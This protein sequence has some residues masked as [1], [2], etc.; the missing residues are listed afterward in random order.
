MANLIE[1]LLSEMNR[2]RELIKEYESLPDNAGWFGSSMMK[3]AI[4]N[5][6]DAM[7]KGDVVAELKAYQE[8]KDCT[9]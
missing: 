9:G 1:G 8:L 6:E 7:A 4:K 2:V 3:V 5:A